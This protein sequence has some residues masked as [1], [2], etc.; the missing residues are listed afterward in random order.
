MKILTV[1]LEEK[2]IKSKQSTLNKL[3]R[4]EEVEDQ[5][6][7]QVKNILDND[8]NQDI[9]TLQSAGFS[10]AI[11]NANAVKTK[12]EGIKKTRVNLSNQRIF[13][14]KE[15]KALAIEYGL[16][17]LDTNLYKGILDNEL[18][19]KI[20]EAEEIN[21]DLVKVIR[22]SCNTIDFD[23]IVRDN[24]DLIEYNYPQIEQYLRIR[25]QLNQYT[26]YNYTDKKAF[27]YKILAPKESFNLQT[28]PKD[29]LLFLE[30]AGGTYYLVHKWGNDLSVF[31]SRLIKTMS[32]F[33]L[34][35]LPVIYITYN[36]NWKFVFLLG[37]SAILAAWLGDNNT[38]SDNW[39]SKFID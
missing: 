5:L 11:N 30:L 32:L 35:S 26:N 6:L 28:R 31:K 9:N 19:A 21:K 37:I 29:P 13:T 15:I 2:L 33:I 20:K 34:A 23:R 12:S 17:F 22:K 1:N 16:R 25:G 3:K 8:N 10:T 27:N 14:I 18:P 7:S 38:D 4:E 24:P 36:Y 39:D